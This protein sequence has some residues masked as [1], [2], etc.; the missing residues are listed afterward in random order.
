MSGAAVRA[1]KRAY[2]ASTIRG[3]RGRTRVPLVAGAVAAAMVAVVPSAAQAA[4]VTRYVD[5]NPAVCSDTGSG[6]QVQPYCTLSKGISALGAGNTLM[7]M[8]GNYTGGVTI[9]ASYAGTSAQPTTI[10]SAT[11]RGAVI[12]ASATA[13]ITLNKTSFVVVDGFKIDGTTKEGIGAYSSQNVTIRGN[14]ISHAGSPLMGAVANGIE[15]SGTTTSTVSGN[16]LHDNSNDGI[17]LL[18]SAGAVPEKSSDNTISGNTSTNNA[19]GYIRSA[20]GILVNGDNN[21][22]TGN[23]TANNEDTGIQVSAAGSTAAPASGNF[24]LSNLSYGNGDHGIDLSQGPN[25]SILGNSIYQNATAGID[26]ESNSSGITVVDN[27]S[28]ENAIDGTRTRGQIRVDT[29]SQAGTTVNS[30]LVYNSADQPLYTW[31][32]TQYSLITTFR[33]AS[34]Q[35]AADISG[36][37][38]WVSPGTG[39]FHLTSG[40]PAIDDADTTVPGWPNCDKENVCPHNDRGALEFVPAAATA[41]AA[42]TGVTAQADVASAFVKWTAPD[43]GGSSITGYTVTGSPGGTVTVPGSA[44]SATVTGLKNGTAYTF[45]VKATNAVGTGPASKPSNSITTP[46]KPKAP[47]AVTAVAGHGSAG[48]SWTAPS[49]GGSAITGYTVTTLPDGTTTHVAAGVTAVAISGLTDGKTY[50]F[51]VTANNAVGEGPAGVSNAVVPTP[52]SASVDR[53]GGANRFDTSALI[54]AKSFPAGV[55]V[56][57]VASGLQFPDAL[58]A[59]PVA[60]M[61]KGPVLLAQTSS[62]SSSVSAELKRL[63]PKKIVIL[64]G[65]GAVSGTVQKT[66]AG[67]TTGAVERWGGANRFDTSALISA[68]S[69]PADVNV[70]YVASGLVFPDALAGGPVAAMTGGPVLLSRTGGLD[71]SITTELRRL[72]PAAI[73]ILGGAASVSDSVRAQ[74]AAYVR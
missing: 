69:F 31:G 53:W 12:N 65:T 59:A 60:G 37:P 61:T 64:G 45:T 54:S 16:Y 34:G 27:I 42:P 51:S 58:S 43:N 6:T 1:V 5:S 52:T 73:V 47:T 41:P 55:N 7:V 50:T 67:Y 8:P 56:A 72:H 28:A 15:L 63:R 71:S 4:G 14:E 68:K 70:V 40:S 36:N 18:S 2:W 22:I 35:G 48:V 21:R 3:S 30:N 44:T 33:A 10:K 17:A 62:L 26:A 49:D 39:D 57:Y 74:L 38:K 9:G 23:V 24:V 29:G 25:T 19:R 11:P 32:T 20:T 46:D 66:L 13:G